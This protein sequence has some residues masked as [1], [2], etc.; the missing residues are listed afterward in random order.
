MVL[1]GGADHRGAADVDVLDDLVLARPR[2]HRLP[3]G[4][5]VDDDQIE[6]RHTEVLELGQVIR[7][8]RVR[9]QA[10]V[11][12]RVQGL[13]A[14]LEALRKTGE[15]L[16]ARHGQSETSDQGCRAPR[17]DELHARIGQAADEVLQAGLVED[18]DEGATHGANVLSGSGWG[19]LDGHGAPI[20]GRRVAAAWAG[21]P[22]R[23]ML[24]IELPGGDP[25]SPVVDGESTG[26]RGSL[27]R[28]PGAALGAWAVVVRRA[29]RDRQ[30]CRRPAC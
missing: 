15:L 6:G 4:V 3:E 27:Q 5:E 10:G 17:G 2:G 30:G 29:D 8:A 26:R 16:D 13:H 25:P 14:T 21:A 23:A 9:E 28:P 22:R 18:R 24:A 12:H 1:G 7:L 19:D 11:H 20:G